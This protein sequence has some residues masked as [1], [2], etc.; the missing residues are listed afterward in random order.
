LEATKIACTAK[1]RP[2]D[3]PINNVDPNGLDDED[4]PEPQEVAMGGGGCGMPKAPPRVTIAEGSPY[5]DDK[6]LHRVP[7]IN[8][9]LIQGGARV[10]PG[11]SSTDFVKALES[12]T[13]IFI[14]T[15]HN[16]VNTG[17][18]RLSDGPTSVDELFSKA[19][20]L[21]KFVVMDACSTA[22][23]L[24]SYSWGGTTFIGVTGTLWNNQEM[25]NR[26]GV[27]AGNS[28]QNDDPIGTFSNKENLKTLH[29]LPNIVVQPNN[30]FPTQVLTP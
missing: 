1:L 24:P 21:P 30:P 14:Y 23:D 28:L 5:T 19:K 8:D 17:Q 2:S 9:D 10:I 4:A 15:G 27:Y 7:S 16:F 13:D 29:G 22:F 12:T 25:A 6:G 20:S 18:I 11:I 26:L 3:C